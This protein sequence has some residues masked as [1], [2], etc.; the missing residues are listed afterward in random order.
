MNLV[1]RRVIFFIACSIAFS[2]SAQTDLVA[3]VTGNVTGTVENENGELVPPQAAVSGTV[4]ATD[5]NGVI[6]AN[7]SGTASCTGGL[8]LHFTFEAQYDSNSNSFTGMYSHTPGAAPD[9]ALSFS[10]DGGFAWTAHL[11][12]EAPSNTGP[13]SY[14]LS[15]QFEIP[16]TA[17]FQGNEVPAE[18]SYGG[19]LSTTQSVSIPLSIPQAGIN[20]TLDYSV[21]FDGSWSAVAVP[22]VDETF[23]FTGEASGTFASTETLTVT[24][25][26]PGLGALSIPVA[27]S[28]S[29][30][31]S[32]FMIDE[33]T[34]AFQGSWVGSGADQ[35][36][37]GDTTITIEFQDTSAFPFSVS[38]SIPVQTG[39]AL[40]PTIEIPFSVSGTFPLSIQQ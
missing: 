6:T 9:R 23:T 12:G 33:D 28:G 20:Q 32:L 7:V 1:I 24:G 26:V 27:I 17:I 40:L 19:T 11:S 22:L 18:R 34:V 15:F 5:N 31:G 29:F 4:V 14:D 16:E 13:R 35:T 25:M 10:N 21:V 8:G 30:G 39:V 37:G 3:P 2:A 36:F 38:G